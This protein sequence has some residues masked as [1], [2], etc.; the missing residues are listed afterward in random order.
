MK[1]F[2]DTFSQ[3]VQARYSYRFDE[4][5]WGAKFASAFDVDENGNLTLVVDKVG[6]IEGAG[7]TG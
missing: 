1:A 3:T 4:I 7:L 6:A 2:D 5:V